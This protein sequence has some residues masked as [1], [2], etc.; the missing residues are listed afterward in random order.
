MTFTFALCLC[1]QFIS[2]LSIEATVNNA[3]QRTKHEQAGYDACV[4]CLNPFERDACYEA[5]TQQGDY[6]SLMAQTDFS[7]GDQALIEFAWGWNSAL[8]TFKD[9]VPLVERK[10]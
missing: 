2:R 4:A 3:T 6:R 5:W 7:L 1:C 9:G 10:P 8:Q